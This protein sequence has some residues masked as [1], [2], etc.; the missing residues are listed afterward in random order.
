[1]K[2]SP[3]QLKQYALT[4]VSVKA[5]PEHTSAGDDADAQH[6]PISAEV[7]RAAS[8]E[9]PRE[10]KVDLKVALGQSDP[11]ALPYFVQIAATGIFEVMPQVP[12]DFIERIVSANGPAVLYG[13]MREVVASI[14]GRGPHPALLLPSVTFIDMAPPAEQQTQQAEKTAPRQG[15]KP[16]RRPAKAA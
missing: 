2:I 1:M 13:A 16:R 7:C 12:D 8:S 9:N 10:W 3:L 14:T 11:G 5:N 6:T 15:A 4:E